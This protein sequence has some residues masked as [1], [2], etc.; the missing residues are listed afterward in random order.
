MSGPIATWAVRRPRAAL[1]HFPTPLEHAERLS[2]ALGVQLLIK[3]EDLSGGAFG[4]NK[5]R[6]LALLA[7]APE[8]AAADVWIAM[9]GPQSNYVRETAAAAARLGKRAI[10][11][12]RGERPDAA[13]QA[14]EAGSGNLLVDELLG[15]ELRYV[16]GE[17]ADVAAAMDAEV[18]RCAADGVR[19]YAF[20]LGGA[21]ALG[22]AAW[23]LGAQELLA[24]ADA[25]G[26]QPDAV[27]LGAGT[28]STALGAA[29]GLREAGSDAVLHAISASWSG[30]QLAAEAE[31]LA[32]ELA[33]A[34]GVAVAV[35]DQLRW[36]DREVG[37]GYTQATPAGCRALHAL[38]R[39]HGLVA[40]LTY[41]G[42][43]F[44]GLCRL[45][46]E[47]HL[48]PGCTVVFVHTGGTPELFARAR[49]AVLMPRPSRPQEERT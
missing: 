49:A 24:Q 35:P 42:K 10:G 41:S 3:R 22:V 39:S 12:L 6:K 4:G 47:G 15:A 26:A 29:L 40:D 27:V 1:G 25:A 9:G 14:R 44:A 46:E 31:R 8:A 19:A 28:G 2:D 18:A 23:H 17:W 33:A 37:P 38:A 11:F 7:A 13:A 48:R 16:P 36:D 5:V 45:V 21:D 20:P 43:A 30:A 34:T 32:A